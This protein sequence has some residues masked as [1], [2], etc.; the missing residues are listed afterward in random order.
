MEIKRL[1]TAGIN[2]QSIHFRV[3]SCV[4]CFQTLIFFYLVTYPV[5]WIAKFFGVH[6]NEVNNPFG[7]TLLHDKFYWTDQNTEGVY[8]ADVNTGA[9]VVLMAGDLDTPLDI[10]AYSAISKQ[11]KCV[12]HILQQYLKSVL[13]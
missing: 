1:N 9:N 12:Y 6:V 5:G 11:R 8:R 4:I 2:A 10:H 13:Q 7:L 3:S